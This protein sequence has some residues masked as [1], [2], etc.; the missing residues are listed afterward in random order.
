MNVNDVKVNLEQ[1]FGDQIDVS[2]D[3]D[4]VWVGGETYSIRNDLKLLGA[5][6][7]RN[8]QQ[9]Y[10]ICNGENGKTLKKNKTKKKKAK[11]KVDLI[12]F[13]LSW[14]AYDDE[15]LMSY[16]VTEIEA[17]SEARAKVIATQSVKG[18]AQP[19][20]DDDERTI[21]HRQQ[22]SSAIKLGNGK[23][24]RSISKETNKFIYFKRLG[25]MWS[26]GE[27]IALKQL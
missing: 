27:Y 25:G 13:R 15:R 16:G 23:W 9:W 1:Q 24:K 17:V 10:I 7:A 6:W 12:R 14:G 26:Q 20:K 3:R 8:K 21:R 4:W 2:I 22:I 5:K 19:H 18:W 11:K